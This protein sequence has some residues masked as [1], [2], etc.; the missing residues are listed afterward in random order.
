MAIFL[1]A[2]CGNK[3]EEQVVDELEVKMKQ[4]N[5]YK[6]KGTM[7]ISMSYDTQKY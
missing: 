3:T 6:L 2:A 7:T 4:M 1:L 5:G